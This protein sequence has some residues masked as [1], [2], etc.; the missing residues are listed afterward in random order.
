[1]FRCG[2]PSTRGS[3][4]S[5]HPAF[6]RLSSLLS[7]RLEH[8]PLTYN[9]RPFVHREDNAP[10][11]AT[12]MQKR[13]NGPGR[14]GATKR[15]KEQQDRGNTTNGT[16]EEVLDIEARTLLEKLCL[17]SRGQAG[18]E[19]GDLNAESHL[20]SE[21]PRPERPEPQ[22]ELE[23]EIQEL[24]ST[25]NGLAYAPDK[26]KHF[27]YVVPFAVPGDTVVAKTYP[28]KPDRRAWT[29]VDLV[30]IVSPSA[31]REGVTP[32]CPYFGTCSGCQFQ[33][34]PYGAQLAHK[35]TIVEKAFRHFSNLDPSLVPT[36]DDTIG[37]PLEYGYRTKITPHYDGCSRANPWK[38]GDEPPPFG[39]G[40]K[41]QNAGR[42]LDIEQCPIATE[43]LNAGLKIERK[44]VAQT[45]WKKR[46]GTTVLLR[47]ST[48]REVLSNDIV[49]NHSELDEDAA[50]DANTAA[51]AQDLSSLALKFPGPPS[52]TSSSSSSSTAQITYTYPH[53]RD[54]KTYTSDHHAV[55][56]E[57]IGP[58]T[59]K[60]QANSFF[61]N[62]NSI[63]PSFLAY[64]RDNILPVPPPCDPSK[65]A[66]SPPRIKYLLDAY[67]GSGLFSI[68]LASRFSSVL[69][70]DID[71]PS[72]EC[73]RENATINAA[74]HNHLRG[75]TNGKGTGNDKDTFSS[76]LGFIAADAQ[77]I[78]DDV[79]FPAAQT[80]CIIDPPRKGASRDFLRQLSVFGPRRVVYVSCNV[81]TQARDVGMLVAGMEG[82]E[83]GQTGAAPQK[84]WR[85]EIEKV[86]GFD[87]F[88]QTGHVE[89][90]CF[91]NRVEDS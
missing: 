31:M 67:C 89:G 41:N 12:R 75:D 79:P 42:V 85:Y 44:K 91:L 37:S 16:V 59:F 34:L 62:N 33:M 25:G 82:T 39:F 58:F 60:T 20:K 70:I 87:F 69:G 46:T 38:Q 28:Q 22:T 90:V 64:I 53:F 30:K 7:P 24:S 73:A 3:L 50:S 71:G 49:E 2:P 29:K 5:F 23:L 40:N 88:P 10:P 26:N 45:F 81:H 43:V 21:T 18:D 84:R 56:T 11:T 66:S 77:R 35:K 13:E 65:P 80:V 86:G 47:E 8:R 1:M 4:T 78:F 36:V 68:A 51:G 9:F 55:T 6:W 48:K 57:H 14:G 54:V 61:Q 76:N 17:E 19:K 15:F 74:V 63:L 52:S 83:G 32:K 72:I 27:V